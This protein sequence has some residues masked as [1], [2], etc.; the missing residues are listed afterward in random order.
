MPCNFSSIDNVQAEGIIHG[1]VFS[2]STDTEVLVSFP[3]LWNN[4]DMLHNNTIVYAWEVP[5][6]E[7][8]HKGKQWYWLVGLAAAIIITVAILLQ[9]YLLGFLIVLATFLIVTQAKKEPGILNVEISE[10]GIRLGD[11]EHS[12]ES[13]G[14]FWMKEVGDEVILIILTSEN[15]HHLRS[16]PIP[17]EFDPL[18]IREY[19]L[20]FVEE[21]ELRESFTDRII[22]FMGF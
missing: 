5:E 8:R 6:F 16:I 12:F 17:P 11:K 19:L 2:A 13:I 9:N 21:Q 4:E 20:N 22:K 7:Y 14:A 10:A 18:E 15:L 3:L 1:L